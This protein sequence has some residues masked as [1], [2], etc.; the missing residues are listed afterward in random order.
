MENLRNRAE[1]FILDRRGIVTYW[2]IRLDFNF[3][4]DTIS[5]TSLGKH[6]LT[7]LVYL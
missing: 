5:F 4:S 6:N 1:M 7:E 3:I 2:E